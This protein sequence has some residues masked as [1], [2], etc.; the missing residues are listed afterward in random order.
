M[1]RCSWFF[2]RIL[3]GPCCTSTW[4]FCIISDPAAQ[5]EIILSD[6]IFSSDRLHRNV[7]KVKVLVYFPKG[8]FPFALREKLWLKLCSPGKKLLRSAVVCGS[9]WAA[10]SAIWVCFMP[11]PR[12]AAPGK[13]CFPHF[14]THLFEKPLQ[15]IAIKA[16]RSGS[17]KLTLSSHRT[18]VNISPLNDW[19]QL[20][21][22]HW[23]NLLFNDAMKK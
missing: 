21:A 7:S 10:D 22:L 5:K 18:A 8:F 6:T 15:T 3:C 4:L 9:R 13:A 2:M 23:L 12:F 19:G 1:G 11:C 17:L 20:P 14:G 16:G